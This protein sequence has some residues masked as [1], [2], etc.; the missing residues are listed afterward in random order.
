MDF[1][2]MMAQMIQS[3]DK[4]Y[5]IRDL[6]ALR[7]AL[8]RAPLLDLRRGDNI[9]QKKLGEGYRTSNN[10]NPVKFVRYLTDLERALY[11]RT[12][13]QKIYNYDAVMLNFVDAR[14]GEAAMYLI[15]T[16]EYERYITQGEKIM[17]EIEAQQ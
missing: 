16:T 9:V 5:E 13:G 15:D 14:D 4:S 7:D 10:G 17:A 11:N 12:D 3:K 1:E 8:D 6:N 2:K